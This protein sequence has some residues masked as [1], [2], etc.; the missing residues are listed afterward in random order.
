MEL[1]KIPSESQAKEHAR[2]ALSDIKVGLQPR[3]TKSLF[4]IQNYGMREKNSRIITKTA[5][6]FTLLKSHI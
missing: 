4:V 5:A 6:C 3:G 1:E 2:T